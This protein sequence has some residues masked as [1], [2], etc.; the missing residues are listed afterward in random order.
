MAVSPN[1]RINDLL[2]ASFDSIRRNTTR[3]LLTVLGIVIGI[4]AVIV[5][6]SIG[7]GAQGYVL[8][9]VAS[10]GSDQIFIESGSGD[11][12]RIGEDQHPWP[13]PTRIGG[14]APS[15]APAGKSF[16]NPWES[17][18]RRAGAA[19]LNRWRSYGALPLGLL[20]QTDAV[21]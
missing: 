16:P 11:H 13:T 20:L 2:T 6:L 5:M 9:Q 21:T 19:R 18:D 1:M 8:N 17:G 4:G 3:S 7:Q 12:P 15:P 10:L 14:K